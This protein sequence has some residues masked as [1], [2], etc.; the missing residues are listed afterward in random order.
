M[1]LVPHHI[2]FMTPVMC[3]FTLSHSPSC[4]ISYCVVV[5]Q[6]SA[7]AQQIIIIVLLHIYSLLHSPLFATSILPDPYMLLPL[8]ISASLTVTDTQSLP[9]SKLAHVPKGLPTTDLIHGLLQWNMF[10][11]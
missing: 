5:Y 10:K 6:V 1:R 8:R 3:L 9:V 11:L 4:D 7:Y 2:F